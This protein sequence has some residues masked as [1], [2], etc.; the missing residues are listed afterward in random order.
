M[1]SAECASKSSSHLHEFAS[2]PFLSVFQIRIPEGTESLYLTPFSTTGKYLSNEGDA[3]L[4]RNDLGSIRT[5]VH[6]IARC[7][8][9]GKWLYILSWHDS[10]RRSGRTRFLSSSHYVSSTVVHVHL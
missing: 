2:K 3:K 8:S 6:L 1:L 5:I 10:H 4:I 9:H 7:R